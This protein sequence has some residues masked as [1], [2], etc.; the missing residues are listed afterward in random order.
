MNNIIDVRLLINTPLIDKAWRD[1]KYNNLLTYT[2]FGNASSLN[3]PAISYCGNTL[4]SEKREQAQ[5][6]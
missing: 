4:S 6:S 1:G 5:H 2:T 3:F